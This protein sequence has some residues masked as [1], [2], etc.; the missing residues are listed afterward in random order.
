[1]DGSD[2]RVTLNSFQDSMQESVT[3]EAVTLH[4]TRDDHV[5]GASVASARRV[6]IPFTTSASRSRGSRVALV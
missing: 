6:A 4:V 1:M 2:G 5:F 3:Q